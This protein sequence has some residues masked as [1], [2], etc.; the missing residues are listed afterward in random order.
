M[1]LMIHHYSDSD[2]EQFINN[3]VKCSTMNEARYYMREYACEA[4]QEYE[5]AGT[6]KSIVDRKDSI[7]IKAEYST[8]YF[9][10]YF[11]EC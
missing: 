2:G 6:F 8:D 9:E 10:V 3:V 7:T 5:D 11:I 4:L 1:Y